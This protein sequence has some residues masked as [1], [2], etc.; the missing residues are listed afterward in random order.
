[1][2]RR[3]LAAKIAPG[4][5]DR[6]AELEAELRQRDEIIKLLSAEL[7]RR[8]E[9]DRLRAAAFRV[10]K[11]SRARLPDAIGEQVKTGAELVKAAKGLGR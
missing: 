1:M 4:D 3:S 7:F 6:I 8:K 9:F 11:K 5:A 2:P 10:R